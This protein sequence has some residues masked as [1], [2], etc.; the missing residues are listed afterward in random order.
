MLKEHVQGRCSHCGRTMAKKSRVVVLWVRAAWTPVPSV[1]GSPLTG[2]LHLKA[3]T[4]RWVTGLQ[5]QPSFSSLAA[6][7]SQ[8]NMSHCA[9]VAW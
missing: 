1:T 3:L 7:Y 9:H 8:L 4:G 6:L 2:E 5:V